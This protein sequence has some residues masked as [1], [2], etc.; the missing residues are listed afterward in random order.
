MKAFTLSSSGRLMALSFSFALLGGGI[1]TQLPKPASLYVMSLSLFAA[2]VLNIVGLPEAIEDF[3]YEAILSAIALPVALFLYVIGLG[4]VTTFHP[5][6]GYAILAAGVVTL[7]FALRPASL[8]LAPRKGRV[9][10][11]GGR[12]APLRT[13]AAHGGAG[14][15]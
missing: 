11:A 13:V 2:V 10:D 7:G 15:H 1:S 9:S 3:A 8:K 5:T 4:V 12:T 14:S 6:A